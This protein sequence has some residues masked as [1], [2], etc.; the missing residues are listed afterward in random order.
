MQVDTIATRII[1][2][3]ERLEALVLRDWDPVAIEA[4]IEGNIPAKALLQRWA[5]Q[6]KP[7]NTLMWEMLPQHNR[8][9]EPRDG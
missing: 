8:L 4:E 2:V 5:Q 6:V 3:R 7:P 9:D 1:P